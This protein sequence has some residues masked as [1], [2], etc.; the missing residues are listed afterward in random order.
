MKKFMNILT[1]AALMICN[2]MMLSAAVDNGLSEVPEPASVIMMGAG[3]AGMAFV[4]W[5]RNR[6]K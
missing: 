1:P 2:A 3:L 6:N 5:K 4:G